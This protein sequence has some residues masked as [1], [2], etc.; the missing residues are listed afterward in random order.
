VPLIEG[1]VLDLDGLSLSFMGAKSFT[2][3]VAE[4]APRR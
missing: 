2:G 3:W 1:A 4:H